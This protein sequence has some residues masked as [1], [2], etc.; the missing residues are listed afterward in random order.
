MNTSLLIIGAGPF[1]LAM[2]AHAKHLGINFIMV[3]R[4]MEFWKTNM[5][6]G[7]YL[8]SACDWHLDPENEDTME[9]FLA[10][11]HLSPADV[12][13]LSRNF[14]LSYTEWFQKQK[15]IAALP[16]Y[17][18]HLDYV[19]NQYRAITDEGDV[20]T[21]NNVVIAVGFK[22]FTHLPAEITNLLS[23][24]FYSHTCDVTDM[25]AMQGKRCLILGGRQSAFEWAALLIEAGSATIH[26]SHRHKSPAFT[27]SDWSWVNPIVDNMV[28][29]PGWF[30]NLAAEGKDSLSKKLWEEGRLKIEPWLE[31][32]VMNDNV[33]LLPCTEIVACKKLPGGGLEVEFNKGT[34]IIVDHIIL[35]TGYK[36][37]INRVPFL[38]KGNIL[39][40][41]SIQNNF[42]ALDEHFQTNLPG[43]F[44]TSMPASQDFGPFFGFTIAVRTSAKL[45]G[46]A[47]KV[48]R[49][50]SILQ[51]G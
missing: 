7:M 36:V 6:E 18:D 49:E 45:I 38:N 23:P 33:K 17:I 24:G 26:I 37:M 46:E 9:K 32:R 51:V 30:R 12:G 31:K 13:P 19:D 10:M 35:A 48:S 1:G 3:G 20:I 16:V 44:I 21:A 22:Y 8:R 2:A 29:E 28:H 50:R 4:P 15:Q 41:L 47:L 42:P 39:S 34:T 25:K 11:K 14:Y 40:K 5:P 43:L 27:A